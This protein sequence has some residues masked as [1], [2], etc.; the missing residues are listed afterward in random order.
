MLEGANGLEFQGLFTRDLGVQLHGEMF[1][2]KKG[3]R[4]PII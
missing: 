2:F 1:R 3:Q 4:I